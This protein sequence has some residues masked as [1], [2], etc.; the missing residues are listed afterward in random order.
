VL[1]VDDLRLG[2]VS[3]VLPKT[4]S[5]SRGLDISASELEVLSLLGILHQVITDQYDTRYRTV[6][7]RPPYYSVI[8]YNHLFILLSALRIRDVSEYFPS[9]IPDLHQRI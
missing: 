9:R 8:F 3:S 6:S 1:L 4:L 5:D 7:L 2:P